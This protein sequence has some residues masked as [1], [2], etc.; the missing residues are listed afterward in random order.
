MSK[1]IKKLFCNVLTLALFAGMLTTGFAADDATEAAAET[2]KEKIPISYGLVPTATTGAPSLTEAFTE[3]AVP[4]IEDG[5]PVALLSVDGTGGAITQIVDLNTQKVIRHFRMPHA[6]YTYH[7][8]TTPDG[9]IYY[10]IGKEIYRYDPSVKKPEHIAT[11]PTA[12]SGGITITWDEDSKM[13]Y[14]GGSNYGNIFR[15]NPATKEIKTLTS[16]NP[17]CLSASRVEVIGDYVY[18]GGGYSLTDGGSTHVFKIDKY[19]G[20][21]TELP[22]PDGHPIKSVGY[23]ERAG[24]YL[25]ISLGFTDGH[26]SADYI[27]DTEKEEWLDQTIAR[28]GDHYSQELDGKKYFLN[29]QGVFS[30]VDLETLE[31]EAYDGMTFGSNFR[32][33]GW[34]VELKDPEL[35][36]KNIITAQYHGNIYVFNLQTKKVKHLSQLQLV[37]SAVPNRISRIMPDGRVY[38]MV[39]KGTKGSAW[40]PNTGAIEYYSAGQGEGMVYV[41][42]TGKIYAGNYPGGFIYAYDP[43]KPYSTAIGD[44]AS[45]ANPYT[46]GNMGQ[47]QDRPFTMKVVGDYVVIGTLPKAGGVDGALSLMNIETEEI[48]IF[49]NI[50][51]HQS[52]LS[53][54]TK[55]DG[56]TVYAS[57]TVTGGSASTPLAS[58]SHIFSFDV[59]TKQI[60]KDIELKIPG[61]TGGIGGIRGVL[62]GP[63]DLLYAYVADGALV[64]LDPETLEVLRYNVYGSVH[65][66][67]KSNA[68]IWHEVLMEFDKETGYLCVGG[69][70]YDPETLEV[71]CQ[72]P[73]EYGSYAGMSEDGEYA[74][75]V[76]GECVAYQVPII[77]GEDKSYLIQTLSFFKEG[78]E[79][80][81]KAGKGVAFKTYED[82]GRTMVPARAAAGMMGGSVSWDDT[83]KSVILGTGDGQTLAFVANDNKVTINGETKWFGVTMKVEDGISY[84]PMQTLCDFYKKDISVIDGVTFVHD[85]VDK[86]EVSAEALDYIKS[87]V[88]TV[89]E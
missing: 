39:F 44:K 82:N 81:Y 15:C 14:G 7:G 3:M 50:I 71:V 46:L 22:D 24:K 26:P 84:I 88:Y 49:R 67:M 73:A 48:E 17:E 65:V 72:A 6:G 56:K 47:D 52:I 66:N 1:F 34:P 4:T 60:I 9:I 23:A 13:L 70:F 89:E 11:G 38:T 74:Y 64:V 85:I 10:T 42:K 2:T 16:V 62:Y 27:W 61:V 75:F 77:R 8:L 58:G 86:F 37:G 63:D 36:G 83:T 19:T 20:D 59:E 55:G 12:W 5:R 28:K 80:L 21:R 18:G 87:E 54:T 40:D 32:G 33:A 43:T 57:T 68:Q 30:S 79:Y 51:P 29:P 76:T 41:E 45:G 69:T 25:I 53:V 35:P 31:V 78:D